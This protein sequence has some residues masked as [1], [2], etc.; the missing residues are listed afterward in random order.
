MRAKLDRKGRLKMV[1]EE[2]RIL[3][4]REWRSRAADTESWTRVKGA[5]RLNASG[6]RVL[7]A[8]CNLRDMRAKEMDRPPYK[9]FPDAATSPARP[10]HPPAT[11]CGRPSASCCA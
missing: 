3:A 11:G 7:R 6:Q 2:C 4:E 5:N 10:A 8:L 1:E 9:V